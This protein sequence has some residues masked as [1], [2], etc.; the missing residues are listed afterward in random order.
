MTADLFTAGAE[1]LPAEQ[2]LLYQ[3]KMTLQMRDEMR[4]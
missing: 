2:M 4:R 1:D 3:L